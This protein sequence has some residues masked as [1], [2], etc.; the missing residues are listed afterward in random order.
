MFAAKMKVFSIILLATL[1]VCQTETADVDEDLT[2]G[3][4]YKK[5]Q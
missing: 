3:K 1:T 2:K 4:K 5:I